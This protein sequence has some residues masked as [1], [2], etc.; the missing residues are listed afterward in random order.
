MITARM[1][2][3]ALSHARTPRSYE[4]IPTAVPSLS[5]Y[6]ADNLT[7]PISALFEPRFYVLL[8][9]AKHLVIAGQKLLMRPGDCALSM[10]GLPFQ[11][12]V[13]E[14]SSD[15][16]YVGA[17]INLDPAA[18][19][20]V[21]ILLA[22][23]GEEAACA[24]ASSALTAELADPVVRLLAL[25]RSPADAMFL[26]PLAEKELIYRLLRGP[27]GG[28][29]RMLYGRSSRFPQ[30]KAAA[31]WIRANAEAPMR[32]E[33]LASQLGMS[34]TSLHRHFRAVTGTSPLA[35]QR[36]IRL[37]A[38]RSRIRSG[39]ESVTSAAFSCGYASTSQFSREYKRMFGVSPVKD[40]P[41]SAS[42][43]NESLKLEDHTTA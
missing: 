14:A 39:S 20:D 21:L 3:D 38:A 1:I 8:Q 29:L 31:D 22:D 10:V 36:H 34:P 25:S 24:F 28:V 18:I 13:V 41:S 40:R 37:L 9:G 15:L 26:A 23:E 32:V 7:A 16:P 19:T 4:P 35:Y 11:T 17:A 12:S 42:T 6:S 33:V 43:R 30:V 2:A 5:I 27:M